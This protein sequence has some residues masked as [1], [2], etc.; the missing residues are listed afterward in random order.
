MITFIDKKGRHIKIEVSDCSA[1]AY[2]SGK[3][4]GD[5]HTTGVREIDPRCEPIP[6]E[7]TGWDV[8]GGFKRAGIAT[9]LVRL[10]VEEI[11]PLAPGKQNMGRGG[12][13]AL[14]DEGMGLTLHCQ[15]LGLV[16]PFPNDE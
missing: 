15:S 6:A 13:N 11:G 2:F 1:E 12:E 5:L 8:D 16:L 14:T 3:L 4:I 9:E 10:L 7:I